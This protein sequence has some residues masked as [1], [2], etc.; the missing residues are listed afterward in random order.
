M[1][2]DLLPEAKKRSQTLGFFLSRA[3]CESGWN[4][5]RDEDPQG[6]PSSQPRARDLAWLSPSV[7]GSYWETQS[8]RGDAAR[9]G[10]VWGYR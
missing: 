8:T 9:V 7:V 5:G 6:A 3:H 10:C 1:E 4:W 2:V